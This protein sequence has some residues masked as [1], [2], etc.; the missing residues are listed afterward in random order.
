MLGAMNAM[1]GGMGKRAIATMLKPHLGDILKTAVMGIIEGGGGDPDTCGC[2]CW[3]G[4]RADGTHTVMATVF[5]LTDLEEPGEVIGTI[6]VLKSMET[7][8]LEDFLADE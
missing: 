3:K 7:L 2:F 1:M 8:N 5:R 4:T 6:D